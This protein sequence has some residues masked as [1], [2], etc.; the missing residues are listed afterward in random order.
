MAKIRFILGAVSAALVAPA[1]FAQTW[2]D[3]VT[4]TTTAKPVADVVAELAKASGMPMSVSGLAKNDIV[5][6][7]LK[8][9]PVRVAADKLAAATGST[10]VEEQGVFVLTR[11]ASDE[12]K[13]WDADAKIRKT[14][15]D[16]AIATTSQNL[17]KS[18]AGDNGNHQYQ[19]SGMRAAMALLRLIPSEQLAGMEP[20]QRF[21]FSTKTTS[22]QKSLP[23]GAMNI[24]RQYLAEDIAWH[25][26]SIQ[27]TR[28]LEQQNGR[29][30]AGIQQTQ[31]SLNRLQN[32]RIG[33]VLLIVQNQGGQ[34]LVVRIDLLDMQN[35]LISTANLVLQVNG[36]RPAAN[37]N[38]PAVAGEPLKY[39]DR[40]KALAAL[41]RR[42]SGGVG[43]TIELSGALFLAVESSQ[44]SFSLSVEP[45]TPEQI[46]AAVRAMAARPDLVDPLDYFTSEMLRLAAESENAGVVACIP[47]SAMFGSAQAVLNAYS[48]KKV[49]ADL[50]MSQMEAKLEDGIYVVSPRLQ[51]LSRYERMNRSAVALLVAEATKKGYSSLDD[52]GRYATNSSRGAFTGPLDE[53]LI[54]IAHPEA[55]NGL[56]RNSGNQEALAIFAALGP[57][58]RENMIMSR[59]AVAVSGV[60]A[61][62]ETRWMT[63][64]SIDGPVWRNPNRRQGRGQ[65][66]FESIPIIGQVFLTETFDFDQRGGGQGVAPGQPYQERTE[67]LPNGLPTGTTVS[68]SSRLDSVLRSSENQDQ[69]SRTALLSPEDLGAQRAQ[70]DS[71]AFADSRASSPEYRA[72]MI[73][74]QGDYTMTLTYADNYTMT[75]RLQEIKISPDSKPMAYADLPDDIRERIDEA[76]Q[77]TY[78]A[79]KNQRVNRSGNRTTQT[80]PP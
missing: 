2:D 30:P 10:W 42:N 43:Q 26:W 75:R 59:S 57:E 60:G 7:S 21:V 15:I 58:R 38:P 3:K 18:R 36:L 22:M 40:A 64:N 24:A 63:Y 76:Y 80:P 67:F 20:D 72:F 1:A 74:E 65:N 78:E 70:R 5:F 16:D 4:I 69:N 62:E 19:A 27:R 51:S 13:Q 68:L 45:E 48:G 52:L 73:A 25:E 6:I 35:Q 12:M 28:E 23:A 14:E 49:W 34:M 55:G 37:Q 41:W 46:E 56:R 53:R 44:V 54:S 77:K 31:A 32:A 17:E 8:D 66:S 29:N 47:D 79:L 9:V 61:L 33:K 71:P 50:K 11:S 39:S